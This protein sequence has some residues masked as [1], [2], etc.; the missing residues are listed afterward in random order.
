MVIP[1]DDLKLEVKKLIMTT[2]NINNVNPDDID[3][4]KPLFGGTNA[5]TLD[6]VDA[7]EIVMAIQRD[8]GFRVAD[9]ALAREV[10]RSVNTIAGFI[11]DQQAKSIENES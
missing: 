1:S 7:I 3:D 8:Y 5:L 6:S 9:Q 10:V 2:L 11:A 4:E